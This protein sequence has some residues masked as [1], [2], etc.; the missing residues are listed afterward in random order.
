MG[1][2]GRQWRPAETRED[3]GDKGRPEKTGETRETRRDQ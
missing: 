2:K 3:R 1:D